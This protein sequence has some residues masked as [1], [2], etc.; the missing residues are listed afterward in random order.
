VIVAEQERDCHAGG[1]RKQAPAI[2][3]RQVPAVQPELECVRG[4]LRIAVGPRKYRDL[5]E[6]GENRQR[7]RPGQL[8][9]RRGGERRSE[10]KRERHEHRFGEQRRAEHGLRQRRCAEHERQAGIDPVA[11]RP[12]AEQ[13]LPP[14]ADV[15][16]VIVDEPVLEREEP[17]RRSEREERH[18]DGSRP[19]LHVS[20]Q[21][22]WMR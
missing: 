13:H 2:R 21:R 20:R 12:F 19:L 8:A 14:A 4:D 6:G 3:A 18:V 16:E 17:E 9:N 15:D 1:H 11:C 7:H 22:G 10:P 5:E